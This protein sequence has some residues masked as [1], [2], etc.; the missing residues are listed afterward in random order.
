M[1]NLVIQLIV[2]AAFLGW[3]QQMPSAVVNRELT[4]VNLTHEAKGKAAAPPPHPPPTWEND[5]Q[6]CIQH[7]HFF[8]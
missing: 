1:L 2:E 5:C 8:S 7:T 6:A 3:I 4:G